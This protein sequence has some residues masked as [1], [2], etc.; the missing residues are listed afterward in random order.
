MSGRRLAGFRAWLWQR[1]TAIYLG[2]FA[3]YL[4]IRWAAA[5]FDDAASLRAWL[6]GTPVWIG[7]V[8]FTVAVLLHAWIGIRDVILDYVKPPVLRL[9]MLV[10][11]ALFLMIHGAWAARLLVSVT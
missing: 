1:V 5:P 7:F 2:G 10:L 4:V 9:L 3:A 11:T 8:V 6:G